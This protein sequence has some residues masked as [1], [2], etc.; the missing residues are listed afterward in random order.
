MKQFAERILGEEPGK[1]P[2]AVP[3]TAE[4]V[5]RVIMDWRYG[6]QAPA[7]EDV[8]RLAVLHEELERLV[9]TH[10]SPLLYLFRRVFR[11]GR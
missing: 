1:T 6:E 2:H 8:E 9:K 3:Q 7:P 4:D 10:V 5:F 11:F